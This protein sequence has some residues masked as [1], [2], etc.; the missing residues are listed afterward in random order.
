MVA[1]DLP[2]TEPKRPYGFPLAVEAEALPP[3]M[4]VEIVED[5]IASYVD[6]DELAVLLAAEAEER[7]WLHRLVNHEVVA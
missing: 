5:A 2:G 6:D 7:A 3:R 4:L 1:L